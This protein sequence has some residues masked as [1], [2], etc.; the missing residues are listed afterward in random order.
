MLLLLLL[1]MV[2]MLLML[3][4]TVDMELKPLLLMLLL[5]LLL[6]LVLMMLVMLIPRQLLLMMLQK[7]GNNLQ[8]T[9]YQHPTGTHGFI[10]SYCH[11]VTAWLDCLAWQS[12]TARENCQSD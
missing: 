8:F 6:L 1:L 9:V 2:L 12:K 10:S 11:Q 4:G 5:M 7:Q 3:C